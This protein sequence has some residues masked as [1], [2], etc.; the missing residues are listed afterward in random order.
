MSSHRESVKAAP[1]GHPNNIKVGVGRIIWV[2]KAM[3]NLS[4]AYENQPW[5][6]L[7][8][9]WVLPGGE[10]TQ[11]AALAYAMADWIDKYSKE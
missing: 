11:N 1:F 3:T 6:S 9:G 2:E 4:V 7:P 10:R 5:E 8:D